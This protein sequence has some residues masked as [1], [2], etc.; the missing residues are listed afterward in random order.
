MSQR[1]VS[2]AT[3]RRALKRLGTNWKRAKPWLTN[4]APH[5]ARIKSGVIG[6][7]GWLAPTPQGC[8][9]LSMRSGGARLAQPCLHA[10]P[11]TKPLRLCQT[12]PNT[13]DLEPKALACYGVL[14]ADTQTMLWRVVDGRPV[15]GVT[16]QFLGGLTAPLAQ[17]QK[18]ASV[19]GEARQHEI[20]SAMM[21]HQL[22]A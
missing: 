11:D 7:S 4:P 14:W 19:N 18:Q 6:A 15:S 22:L 9:A 17:D 1:W 8:W 12:A 21:E 20:T 2:D 5:D 16:T 10:W 3:M 13:Q